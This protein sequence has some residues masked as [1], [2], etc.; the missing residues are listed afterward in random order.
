MSL[1]LLI[2]PLLLGLA[3]CTGGELNYD[4]W[5]SE[6]APASASDASFKAAVGVTCIRGGDKSDGE[7]VNTSGGTVHHYA[8][9]C[10][11]PPGQSQGSGPFD[12]LGL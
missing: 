1:R 10:N 2:V 5:V 12:F 6:N 8:Y 7:V 9:A 4:T 3:A 11:P